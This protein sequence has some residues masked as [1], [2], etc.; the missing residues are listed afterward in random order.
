MFL[1]TSCCTAYIE[2]LAD[3]EDRPFSRAEPCDMRSALPDPSPFTL[4]Y[5]VLHTLPLFSNLEHMTGIGPVHSDFA[6]RRVS[7]SPHVRYNKTYGA[8]GRIRTGA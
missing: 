1:H 3:G 5:F 8:G 2:A 6:D 7:I 4:D